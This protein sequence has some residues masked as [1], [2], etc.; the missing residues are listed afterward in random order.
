MKYM[1]SF[2]LS[3]A[4]VATT[5]MLPATAEIASE[6]QLMVFE[7]TAEDV[8]TAPQTITITYQVG[9]ILVLPA[10][11]VKADDG[12]DITSNDCV[13]GVAAVADGECSITADYTP[14]STVTGKRSFL[15]EINAGSVNSTPIFMSNY[16]DETDEEEARRRIK[17]VVEKVVVSSPTDVDLTSLEEQ[18]E[19]TFEIYIATYEEIRVQGVLSDCDDLA[20]STCG[21]GSGGTT[22]TILFNS[23]TNAVTLTES[24]VI[25]AGLSD[26]RLADFHA[27]HQKYTY[28]IPA[29]GTGSIP[30]DSFDQVG[31]NQLVLRTFY[32]SIRDSERKL[33]INVT[34]LLGSNLEIVSDGNAH[35]VDD[36]GRKL[37]LY[38][39]SSL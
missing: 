22:G 18:T 34:A 6:R 21:N 24:E 4:L 31:N 3:A 27:I 36:R 2:Y 37:G 25:A 20:I 39:T 9:D 32:R 14:T 35:Y 29:T 1:K 26:Y 16:Y 13:D 33:Y 30:A 28:T 11:P 38:G 8:T 19:Y 17:P 7:T 12:F 10:D 15:Y 5:Y 23:N